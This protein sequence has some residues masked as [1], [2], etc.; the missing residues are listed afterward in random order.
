MKIF[1]TAF[2]SNGKTINTLLISSKNLKNETVQTARS[3]VNDVSDSALQTAYSNW[4]TAYVNYMVYNNASSRR[5]R[6]T[7]K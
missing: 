7:S 3:G 1:K 6:Q 4:Q 5:R 2:A